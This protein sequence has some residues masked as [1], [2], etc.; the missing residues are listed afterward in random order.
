LLFLNY[1]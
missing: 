1:P